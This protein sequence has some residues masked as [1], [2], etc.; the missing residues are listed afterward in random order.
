MNI[1]E[2]RSM[3][4]FAECGS[5]GKTALKRGVHRSTISRCLNK[6]EKE[7]QTQL[8][9]ETA[10]G[11]KATEAGQRYLKTAREIIEIHDQLIHTLHSDHKTTLKPFAVA[12]S[13][14]AYLG[15]LKPILEALKQSHPS[16]TFDIQWVLPTQQRPLLKTK[17]VNAVLTTSSWDCEEFSFIPFIQEEMGYYQ[18]ANDAIKTLYLPCCFQEISTLLLPL[19]PFKAESIVLQSNEETALLNAQLNNGVA[20]VYKSSLAKLDYSFF[21]PLPAD[22]L[23]R[24]N[25]GLLMLSECPSMHTLN[26]FKNKEFIP[27]N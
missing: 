7:M 27:W 13:S 10:A 22:P 19:L 15:L 9:V 8:F 21:T 20:L 5:I 25:W 17:R 14:P 11:I 23:T 1:E 6:I 24:R 16:M 3:I 4:D 26:L 2:L 12:A 18:G